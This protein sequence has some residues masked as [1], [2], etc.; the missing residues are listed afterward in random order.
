MS[1][2]NNN[3]TNG[4]ITLSNSN[5]N[6]KRYIIA[7]LVKYQRLNEPQLL[8]KEKQAILNEI[9]SINAVELIDHFNAILDESNSNDAEFEAIH[10]MLLNQ[11]KTP[12]TSCNL[13]LCKMI[14][15]NNRDRINKYQLSQIYYGIKDDA[16]I[17]ILQLLDKIHC[18]LLHSFDFGLKLTQS[19][20]QFV[21]QS[22]NDADAMLKRLKEII[23]KKKKQNISKT[24]TRFDDNRYVTKIN[25]EHLQKQ[26]EFIE[27]KSDCWSIGKR[28]RYSA[29][30]QNNDGFDKMNSGQY[31]EWFVSQKYMDLK[32][33]I[34]S[35]SLKNIPM[36]QWK[37]INSKALQFIQCK[38]IKIMKAAKSIN[39]EFDS[40]PNLVQN[41][42]ISLQHIIC[43]LIYCNFSSIKDSFIDTYNKMNKYENWKDVRAK[44][45][46]THCPQLLRIN[47]AN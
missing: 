3:N 43:V 41:Q 33:E 2:Y 7:I 9:L 5:S 20:Q 40:I 37:Y 13:S 10:Q 39:Y 17:V 8:D 4:D 24:S 35:N 19:E 44:H 46:G 28:W 42:A 34:L 26:E 21:Y 27:F 23:D 14:Q 16:E 29:K 36:N 30:Y 15:R 47:T 38:K 12:I 45:S 22:S 25:N 6:A 32:R 1:N 11:M 31:N 18:F